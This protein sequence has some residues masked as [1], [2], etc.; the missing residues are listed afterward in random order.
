MII[1]NPLRLRNPLPLFHWPGLDQ[2]RKQ[3]PNQHWHVVEIQ[4][5]E[6]DFR[7]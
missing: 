2:R 4:E 3:V 6:H 7:S 1:H 5:V